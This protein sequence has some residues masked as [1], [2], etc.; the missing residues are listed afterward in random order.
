M[1][2]CMAATLTFAIKSV[3]VIININ[4]NNK[5]NFIFFHFLIASYKLALWVMCLL[6][7]SS[8][9]LVLNII[10]M[11]ALE[12][13]ALSALFVETLLGQ[14]KGPKIQKV[15]KESKKWVQNVMFLV[16]MGKKRDVF[17]ESPFI[18]KSLYF[19]SRVYTAINRVHN[20]GMVGIIS[21]TSK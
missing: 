6:L 4:N 5:W 18:G 11:M 9:L 2:A 12:S 8:V 13:S 21:K 1:A 14:G 15:F 20:L 10:S 16:G 7:K 17:K 19:W 3:V